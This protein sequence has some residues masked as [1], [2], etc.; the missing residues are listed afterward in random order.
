MS[1]RP[2]YVLKNKRLSKTK[3]VFI[4]RRNYLD[5]N[6][7]I[8]TEDGWTFE[9]KFTH[10][11]NKCYFRMTVHDDNIF[12]MYGVDCKS[13][14]VRGKK[15]SFGIFFRTTRQNTSFRIKH[16]C[17]NVEFVLHCEGKNIAYDNGKGI[18]K[19]KEEQLMKELE[20][21]REGSKKVIGVP[22]NVAW[23]M[24]HPLQGGAVSPR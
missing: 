2:K 22:K 20:R 14:K 24:A 4:F 23:N 1:D 3:T 18:K 13:T 9:E 15:N 7:F 10:H 17:N 21:P 5:I 11:G 16:E 6:D 12:S 8:K 19:T